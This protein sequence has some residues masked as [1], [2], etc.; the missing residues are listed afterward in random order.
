MLATVGVA[1]GCASVGALGALVSPQ[2]LTRLPPPVVVA[3]GDIERPRPSYTDLAGD[4]RLVPVGLALAVPA[5]LLVGGRL[6]DSPDVLPWLVLLAVCPLLAVVDV[7]TR[8]LP[9]ALI[10][11]GYIGVLVLLAVAVGLEGSWHGLVGAG[12]GWVTMGGC[13]VALWYLGGSGLGYGDVRLAGL[14]ALPLGLL[15]WSA[16][17]TGFATGFVL[18]GLAGLGLLASGRAGLRT[19]M[20]FGPFM[21]AGALVGLLWGGPLGGWIAGT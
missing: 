16:L 5:G 15:G 9:T 10:R 12:L 11:P 3:A 8:L 21:M 18:G 20:P 2:L 17:L 13:Y 7:S 14:L 6:G 1:L 4:R 19:A